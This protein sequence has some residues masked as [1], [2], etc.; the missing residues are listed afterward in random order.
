MAGRSGTVI[1]RNR[2]HNCG[3]L[4]PTN[5]HHGIYVEASNGARIT[6]NWIY[7]NA[8]RGVQ[9]FPDAQKSYVARNVI[10]G[11]GEGVVFSRKS[12]GNI[13]EHNVIS[14]P[15]VRYNVEDFELSGGGN[16]ARG[17]LRLERAPSRPRRDPARHHGPDS[18]RTSSPSRRTQT[19]TPTTSACRPTARASA[20]LQAPCDP[21]R[22][23]RLPPLVDWRL[24]LVQ[25]P[26]SDVDRA[27]TFYTEKAGFNADIDV[28]R[29]GG[30]ALRPAD[31]ARI[32]LLDCHRG[33]ASP[34]C[35][36][37]LLRACSSWF[38]TYT[39]HARSSWTA[40]WR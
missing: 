36:R 2:I 18:R 28:T 26:V 32:G 8:D 29:P 39:P 11:N 24:E 17:K 27:K 38:P 23:S 10:D 35:L 15:V 20:S 6:D 31:A 19:G 30:P 14:N 21:D 13:V 22:A 33:L 16:V 5:H 3:Q 7:D 12:A 1:E 4:P 37:A 25:V 34:T 9:L 40:G